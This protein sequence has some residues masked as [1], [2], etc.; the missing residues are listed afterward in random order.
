MPKNTGLGQGVGLL[1]GASQEEDRYFECRVDKILPNKYQPRALFDEDALNELAASIRE[2]GIIQPLIVQPAP[3]KGKYELVAG[4]RRLRASKIAGLAKVPVIVMDIKSDDSLLE[5]A[6]IEN[7][8]R[9]DLNAIEEAEA[10]QK[11]IERFGYTQEETAKRVGKNRSTI[12]NMLRLLSLPDFIKQDVIS[13]TLS[14]GHARALLKLVNNLEILK[15]VRD[16][17]VLRQLS[18]RQTEALAKKES[19]MKPQSVRQTH[20][21]EPE[22][23][24]AYFTAIT[25]QLTN[26]LGTHVFIQQAGSKGKV[27]IEYYSLDDLKRLTNL[28]LSE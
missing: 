13:Q 10:Y 11:L 1:F 7:I 12:T 27:E 3:E 19:Q 2:N 17:V 20:R 26:R 9:T 18:V 21:Q 24:Q 28:L 25:N 23:P 6:L 15:R 8:Q 14:E 5:L 4:E 22:V 16:E